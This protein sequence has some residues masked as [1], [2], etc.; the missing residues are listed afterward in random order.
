MSSPFHWTS[1]FKEMWDELQNDN[2]N[3]FYPQRILCFVSG[4][5]E[6]SEQTTLPFFAPYL[7][8]DERKAK[9]DF[10]FLLMSSLLFFSSL[11]QTCNS[12]SLRDTECWPPCDVHIS[13]KYSKHW[14]LHK[15]VRSRDTLEVLL[16]RDFPICLLS[17]LEKSKLELKSPTFVILVLN[18]SR[19]VQIFC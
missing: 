6:I 14:F 9:P 8:R 11:L 17:H 5:L 15:D 10:G 4:G 16:K 19:L 2:L 3:H 13:K 1:Y 7:G 12:W 18:F